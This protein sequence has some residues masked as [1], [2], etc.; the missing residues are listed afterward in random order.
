MRI[1][2]IKPSFFKD[3]EIASL[4]PIARILFQGLWCL[5]DCEGRISDRP[6]WIKVE[7][8]PYDEV[9]IEE[10]LQALYEAGFIIRYTVEGKRY[11][12]VRNFK[13]HQRLS[14]K[15]ALIKSEIPAP[16]EGEALGKRSGSVEKV[17]NVRE[18]KGVYGREGKHSVAASPMLPSGGRPFSDPQFVEFW[19]LYPRKAAKGQAA[20]A[21]VSLS[22][23]DRD[24]ALAGSA[25]LS[26]TWATASADRRAFIP[27]PATWLRGRRWEDDPEEVR[28]QAMD[29][30]PG[31]QRPPLVGL[32][33]SD[34]PAVDPA[35]IAE[36]ARLYEERNGGQ[37]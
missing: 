16:S 29:R 2:T 6:L 28:R 11:I 10:L 36:A 25:V 24:L 27:Y 32:R 5:S 23:S 4:A 20:K 22:A 3:D 14:G 15:E 9:D 8:L 34:A 12:E 33:T 1:R 7:C 21:W 18:G 31:P 13:R 17:S 26:A 19:K 37:R 30:A 35:A